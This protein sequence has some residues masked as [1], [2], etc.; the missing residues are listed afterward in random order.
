MGKE[1][2][3]GTQSISRGARPTHAVCMGQ[4]M[5]VDY[6]WGSV[7]PEVPAQPWCR[8]RVCGWNLP[9]RQACDAYLRSLAI[10]QRPDGGTRRCRAPWLHTGP[11]VEKHESHSGG[12]S[13]PSHAHTPFLQWTAKS[14]PLLGADTSRPAR[15]R[16]NSAMSSPPSGVLRHRSEMP[17]S[18][19]SSSVTG[20]VHVLPPVKDPRMV[21][22]PRAGPQADG[23]SG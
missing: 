11:V 1:M 9:Q 17:P 15:G 14:V 20:D 2:Y 22:V 3:R 13:G 10:A 21:Q 4:A 12:H 8:L 18:S 5:S 19:T 16:P 6:Q 23:G 7:Q